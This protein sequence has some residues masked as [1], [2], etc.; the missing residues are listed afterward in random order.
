MV[1]DFF[2]EPSCS[3]VDHGVEIPTQPV[4]CE[5]CLQDGWFRQ[6]GWFRR[7]SAPRGVSKVSPV[8]CRL[9]K[10]TPTRRTSCTASILSK[11][12]AAWFGLSRDTRPNAHSV[13]FSLITLVTS[14]LH[15]AALS[16]QFVC[17]CS[18]HCICDY[19]LAGDCARSLEKLHSSGH[20]AGSQ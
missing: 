10:W 17:L 20:F 16:S 8:V 1:R 6:Q 3:D 2:L 12:G 5:D 4:E 11:C 14:E 15:S 13:T 9:A 19:F 18:G 7:R